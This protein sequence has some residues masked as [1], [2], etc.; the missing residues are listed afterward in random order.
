MSELAPKTWSSYHHYDGLGAA[1]GGYHF[2]VSIVLDAG[3]W[4]LFS[5][6]RVTLIYR[7]TASLKNL[8]SNGQT[9]VVS[10]SF[11]QCAYEVY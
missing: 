4:R 8:V 7:D 5:A 11:A 9:L 6:I 1:F 10:R 3:A 2:M